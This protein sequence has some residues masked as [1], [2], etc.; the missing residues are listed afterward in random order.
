MIESKRAFQILVFLAAFCCLLFELILSRIADFY[1]DSR[2]SFLAIPI[3]FMGLAIGSLHVHFSKRISERFNLKWNLVALAL[4]S[5]L[6]L[7][8]VKNCQFLRLRLN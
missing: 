6:S 3:T 5:F 2:N 1:I 8:A 4:V 7:F